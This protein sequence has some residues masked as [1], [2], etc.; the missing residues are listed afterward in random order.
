ML[1]TNDQRDA[2]LSVKLTVQRSS[3]A[4][5]Q[6]PGGDV[7]WG[8]HWGEN[9]PGWDVGVVLGYQDP[10]N[11]YRVQLSVARGELALW[12]ATGGFLQLISVD[13]KEGKPQDLKIRWSAGHVVVDVNGKKAMDY[14]DRTQPYTHGRVGLA[15]WGSVARVEQFLVEPAKADTGTM[16]PHRPKFRLEP[17]RNILSGHPAFHMDPHN[18]VIL[19]DGNEPIS[20][21]WKEPTDPKAPDSTRGTLCHEAVKLMP[22]WRAAFRTRIGPMGVATNGNSAALVGDLPDAFRVTGGGDSL[23]FK[24][25]TENPNSTHTDYSCT[26][27]Y[28]KKRGVYRYEYQGKTRLAGDV[29]VSSIVLFN[30]LT[31]NSRSPGPEVLHRWNAAS[32]RW[33]VFQA[34]DNQWQ[35]MPIMDYRADDYP[36]SYSCPTLAWGKTADFLY[37]DPAACP[38][39]ETELNWSQ[40]TNRSFSVFVMT[41]GFLFQHQETG[42]DT[43]L[44]NGTE[45]AFAW[46]FTAYPPAEA[47]AIVAKSKLPAAMTGEVKKPIPFVSTGSTFAATGTWENPSTV[48][49]W[50][51]KLDETVGHGDKS[52]LLVTGPGGATL[53]LYQNEVEE[54]TKR[55]WVRGWYKTQGV[56][57][58]TLKLDIAYP[59][60]KDAREVYDLGGGDQDWTYFSLITTVPRVKDRTNIGFFLDAKGTVWLDDIAISGL[61]DDQNPKTTLSPMVLDAKE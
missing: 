56:A 37:P 1:T 46:T 10:L 23:T 24:F 32:H 17:T 59:Y 21:F 22:G 3:G 8:F 5:R 52:S 36:G 41:W 16:P 9:L 45:R 54:F 43:V 47:D 35:R 31:Y 11:F 39:F 61:P 49:S 26:V 7:R 40:P 33:F 34:P 15:V 2:L 55:W 6:L 25:Q 28:D 60:G 50:K 20:Y 27:R 53:H 30:P 29:K 38:A 12:D 48:S 44:S 58:C 42:K 19:F 18:G 57:G 4:Q 14:W 51:G 13:V